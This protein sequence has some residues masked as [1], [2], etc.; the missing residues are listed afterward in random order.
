MRNQAA[1]LKTEYANGTGISE[2]SFNV[3]CE[4]KSVSFKEFY[5][6][7]A[8]GITPRV[9]LDIDPG[10]YEAAKITVGTVITLPNKVLYE[11]N[12]YLIIR[13]FR[14]GNLH[15]ELTLA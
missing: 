10:D 8:V 7:Y 14:K 1:V 5:Q 15:M 4:E 11:G 9:I 3:L 2:S 13:S 6:A 12:E